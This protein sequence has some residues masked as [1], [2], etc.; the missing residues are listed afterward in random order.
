M[1]YLSL[2][3]QF[4]ARKRIHRN[5]VFLKYVKI[6]MTGNSNYKIYSIQKTA[7]YDRL[8]I[9]VVFLLI[10]VLALEH[11]IY[12]IRSDVNCFHR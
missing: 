2:D 4:F 11:T 6:F 3:L 1:L 5:N 9:S 12:Q 7:L 10:M 8:E